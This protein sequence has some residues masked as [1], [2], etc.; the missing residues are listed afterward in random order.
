MYVIK[1]RGGNVEIVVTDHQRVYGFVKA[2]KLESP[3]YNFPRGDRRMD[4][5]I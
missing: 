5:I 4:D 3:R 1:T 2:A